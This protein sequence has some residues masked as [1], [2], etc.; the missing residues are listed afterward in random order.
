MPTPPTPSTQ[1]K[2]KR[3]PAD[4][5]D[6]AVHEAIRSM[7]AWSDL[8]KEILPKYEQ[9]I[10]VEGIE[11]RVNVIQD[12]IAKSLDVLTDTLEHERFQEDKRLPKAIEITQHLLVHLQ[13]IV[14]GNH[15][16]RVANVTGH[17]QP[18]SY[19]LRESRKLLEHKSAEKGADKT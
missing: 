16:T 17:K 1:H 2:Q 10:V 13:S 3:R 8:E 11:I 4:D 9:G 19:L 12:D 6:R 14:F 7:N 18:F 15:Y 5:L